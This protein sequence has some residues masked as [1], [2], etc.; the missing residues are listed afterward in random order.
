VRIL[1]SFQSH[2]KSLH[3]KNQTS[4][5]I[6]EN[7][8]ERGGGGE[9]ERKSNMETVGTNAAWQWSASRFRS[10]PPTGQN[11]SSNKTTFNSCSSPSL[12]HRTLCCIASGGFQYWPSPK[13]GCNSLIQTKKR[14]S[15]VFKLTTV[16]TKPSLRVSHFDLSTEV[17]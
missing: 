8:R 2:S 17:L 15:Y 12:H 7:E 11:Y 10:T 13:T 3:I 16:S 4:I 14:R 1:K 5:Y 6:K 9:R